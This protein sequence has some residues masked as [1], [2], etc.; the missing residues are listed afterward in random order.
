MDYIDSNNVYNLNSTST[1][2]P[3]TW[4]LV[5]LKAAEG[6]G[7]GE[8]H[9]YLN[10]LETLNATGLTNTNNGIDHVSVGGEITADQPVTWY[11][12]SAIAAT[13]YVGPQQPVTTD[14][15]SLTSQVAGKLVPSYYVTNALTSLFFSVGAVAGPILISDLMAVSVS[16]VAFLAISMA[17]Y[18][19]MHKILLKQA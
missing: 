14:A 13:Q 17:L 15:F 8:A 16:C 12:N 3:N 19:K 7:N 10:D 2:S 5:E 9:F 6:A 1:V 4:Y 18:A 11:C